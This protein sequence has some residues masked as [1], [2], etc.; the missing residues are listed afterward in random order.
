MDWTR[1]DWTGGHSNATYGN[2]RAMTCVSLLVT[3]VASARWLFVASALN[4][5]CISFPS[6]PQLGFHFRQEAG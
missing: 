4:C 5:H 2:R 1:L 3:A 6:T